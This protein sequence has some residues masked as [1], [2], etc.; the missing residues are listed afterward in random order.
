VTEP[1]GYVHEWVPASQTDA[2]T[3]LLLHGTGADERD[4]LP[5]G[6][7][8]APGAALLS[9]RG[10]VDEHGMHRF[11]ARHAEGVFDE[12]D[13]VRRAGELAAFVVAAGERYGFDPA[14][15]VAVGFSNGANI[16]AA[17]ML[18]HPDVLRSGVLLAPMPPLSDPP[19]TDLSSSAAFLGAG[20][21]D[22]IGPPELVERLAAE[23]D[24]RG[25]SVTVRFHAGGHEAPREVVDAAGA[26]LHKLAT[27]MGAAPGALP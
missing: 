24:D 4:L 10:N 6:R 18:L 17:A 14:R 7:M 1:L 8:L 27:A 19:A 2:P 13:V 11:F 23:L 12:E 16:A 25:C 22:P 26:W 21:Q 5:L 9:P 15:A 20:R 3:L